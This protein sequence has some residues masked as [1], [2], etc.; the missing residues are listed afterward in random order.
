MAHYYFENQPHGRRK[1]GRK[2]NTKLHYDYISRENS[3]AKLQTKREDLSFSASGNMPN[4]AKSPSDFWEQA[5]KKRRKPDGRAYREF[6]FALQEEFSLQE[7][8]ECIEELLDRTGIKA[9]H[10]YSYAIHDKPATFDKD[11]RNIH[12]HLMFCE[13]IIEPNRPLEADMYFRNYAENDR[14]EAVKGYRSSRE[15]LSVGKTYTLR[16]L[17]ADIVNKKF[18]EKHLNLT[19]S[20]KSLKAQRVEKLREGKDEEAKLLNRTPAPHMGNMYKNP[21]ILQ[22]I[23]NRIEEVEQNSDSDIDINTNSEEDDLK[24]D[25]TNKKIDIFARDVVIRQVAKQIQQERLRLLKLQAE[26]KEE[27]DLVELENQAMIVTVGDVCDYLDEKAAY[28]EEM[29]SEQ[30]FEYNAKKAELVNTKIA[31]R[32]QLFNNQYVKDMNDFKRLVEDYKILE[33]EYK[34][35]KQ[36]ATSLENAV[37]NLYGKPDEVNLLTARLKELNAFKAN[38]LSPCFK[39][40]IA[41]AKA[42]NKVGSRVSEYKKILQSKPQLYTDILNS[43]EVKNKETLKELKVLYARCKRT[44]I[45]INKYQVSRATLATQDKTDI[46]YAHKVPSQLNRMCKI[47]GVTSIKDLKA[48]AFNNRIYIAISEKQIKDKNL[49]KAVRLN[50]DI[51]KGQVPIYYL[52]IKD[53]KAVNLFA[54]TEKVYIYKMKQR[55]EF[56]RNDT[57]ATKTLSPKLQ[58][59]IQKR[60]NAIADKVATIAE[61]LAEDNNK[62]NLKMRWREEDFSIDKVKRVEQDMY[63][64]WSL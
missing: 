28:Y 58:N 38:K 3:Y 2:L 10:A 51:N 32:E 45:L 44:E 47:D 1:D 5:E 27:Y 6:K 52:Q 23:V 24:V 63:N 56:A 41:V 64:D 14:G 7:N 30:T 22:K 43:L 33:R 16:K 15:F 55:D 39:Q 36:K 34:N 46:L 35:L 25:L 60:K 29:L 62:D 21:K 20:E 57:N 8:I 54:S 13:K 61:K 4:W 37:K 26:Q 18:K 9:N 53:D 50:D 11:H 42:K 49:V 19:I 31:A 40:L 48:Y 59:A 12:C 17:Y